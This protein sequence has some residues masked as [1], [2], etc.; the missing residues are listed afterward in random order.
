MSAPRRTPCLVLAGGGHAHVEL[1]RRLALYPRLRH[2]FAAIDLIEPERYMAYSGML[3]ATVAGHYAQ[4]EMQVDITALARLAEVNPHRTRLTRIDAVARAA[5]RADGTRHAYDLLSLNIGAVPRSIA[6]DHHAHVVPAKPVA[7]LWSGLSETERR[8][9]TARQPLRIAVIGGGAGGVELALALA[10]RW[11][12]RRPTPRIALFQRGHTLLGHSEPAA[13]A[14]LDHALVD[15]GIARYA[16]TTIARIAPGTIAT[17]DEREFVADV[18]FMA[19]GAA[20]AP[21][22]EMHGL[23]RDEHSFIRVDARLQSI[24]APGVF[25]AGDIASLPEPRPR[26]GVYAVRAAPVLADNI[27]RAA[28]GR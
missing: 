7:A 9:A 28:A 4:H 24:D 23:A 14:V 25:A 12:H 6:G 17:D 8:L 1:L 19:T 18:V 2:A 5:T 21:G 3:P 20:V 15:A 22:L 27:E 10:H 13:A 11:R 16:G 26:S